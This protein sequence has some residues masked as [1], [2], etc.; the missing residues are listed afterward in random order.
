MTLPPR[1]RR[2]TPPG[3]EDFI[4]G[5]FVLNQ[6]SEVRQRRSLSLFVE[7]E[8]WL[9]RPLRSMTHEDL[10]RWMADQVAA[11]FHVNTVRF[12]RMI[13]AAYWRWAWEAGVIPAEQFMRLRNVKDPRGASANGTPRPYT[14]V[15]VACFWANLD[16]RWP[17]LETDY[18]IRRFVKGTSPWRRVERHARNLQ[19]TAVVMLA[20]TEG[21]RRNEILG[22]TVDELA[23]Q[24]AYLLVR[25][26]RTDHREKRREVP[27]A[28]A[29]R[30]AVVEWLAF[31]KL[32]K[33]RHRSP[34]LALERSQGKP[35][36]PMTEDAFAGITS[37]IG[38][39]YHLHRFRHTFATE[40]ARA[41]M[42][43]PQLQRVM[44]HA[45]LQQTLVY[46]ELI[47]D[48]LERA[49]EDSDV[50]F[51]AAVGRITRRAA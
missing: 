21:L 13:L 42:P 1:V 7:I 23:P 34:W 32:L 17:R 6:I 24:N 33:P 26:K 9:G 47:R 43:W 3:F 5:H 22:I 25:G 15:E 2:P 16:E 11:G 36:R 37:R 41:G 28:P 35:N 18:F 29:C 30:D 39:G 12:K 50:K 44:G 31:R 10:S 20:L 27:Y 40:R 14:R 51:M 46:S 45:T 38:D 19:A 8:E 48:D 49:M 4:H